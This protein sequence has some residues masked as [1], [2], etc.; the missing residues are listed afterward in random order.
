VD[1][2]EAPDICEPI[3]LMRVDI[4]PYQDDRVQDHTPAA[5]LT[6]V[7]A[8]RAS[9]LLTASPV[10]AALGGPPT[11]ALGA[12]QVLTGTGIAMI[13]VAACA[14]ALRIRSTKRHQIRTHALP[15]SDHTPSRR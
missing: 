12:R 3:Q 8:L 14:A 7:L 11:T 4:V 15:V 1:R 2:I 6:T 5:L 13:F 9:V 10:G